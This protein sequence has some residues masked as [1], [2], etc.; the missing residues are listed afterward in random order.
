MGYEDVGDWWTRA[1]RTPSAPIIA[2]PTTAYR[3]EVGVA[4]SVLDPIRNPRQKDH[5]PP[6]VLAQ[7][8]V[9]A[10]ELTGLCPNHITAGTGLDALPHCSSVSSTRISPHVA[11]PIALERHAAGHRLSATLPIGTS[12]HIEARARLDRARRAD[13]RLLSRK[14]WVRSR[15]GATRLPVS[16]GTQH[17]PTAVCMRRCVDLNELETS[18][19]VRRAAISGITAAMTV[20]CLVQEFNTASASAQ[21]VRHGRVCRPHRHI[22]RNWR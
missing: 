10:T 17:T 12:P 18:R 13:G 15:H 3:P 21:T 9:I 7:L 6:K 4:S 5:L 14:V 20:P 8:F 22:G 19:T 1:T 11:G 16:N 2:V